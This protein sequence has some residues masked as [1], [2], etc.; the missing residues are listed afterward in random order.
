MKTLSICSKII[1]HILFVIIFFSTTPVKSLDKY[2]NAVNFSDYFSGILL[3]NDNKY[4]D[5]LKYLK[6]LNGLEASHLNYSNKY[7]YY[8][9]H[10][11]INCN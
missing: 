6:R 9:I 2:D 10:I 11:L 5:S 7:L 4:E 1:G 3:L 8:L